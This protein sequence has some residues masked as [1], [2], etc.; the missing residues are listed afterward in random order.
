MRIPGLKPGWRQQLDSPAKNHRHLFPGRR[1]KTKR[2]LVLLEPKGLYLAAAS[3]PE[4]VLYIIE[5]LYPPQMVPP[6]TLRYRGLAS[7][8]L[9]K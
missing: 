1:P 6:S 8:T 5:E 9:E 4:A 3:L 7:V 2:E